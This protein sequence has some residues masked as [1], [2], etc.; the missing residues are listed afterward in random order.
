[1][2]QILVPYDFSSYSENALDFAYHFALHTSGRIKLLHVVEHNVQLSTRSQ[3]LMGL[4]QQFRKELVKNVTQHFET[5]KVSEKYKGVD[6]DFEVKVGIPLHSIMETIT[7]DKADLIIMGTKGASGIEEFLIGSNAEKVVRLAKCPVITIPL[8]AIF[9]SISDIAF[10]INFED[11]QAYIFDELK[12]IQAQF[13]SKIHLIWINT[14]GIVE[15]EAVIA[16]RL[17]NAASENNLENFEVH[18]LSAATPEKGILK[19]ARDNNNIDMIAMATH[20][21]RGLTHL[22]L[23]SIAENVVNHTHVPVWTTN[24]KT[25][26]GK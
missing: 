21:F 3:A 26:K 23:G 19:F 24:L 9:K 11:E 15:T 16:E 10:A 12:K 17:K 2:K 18:S 22:F 5:L 25:F 6:I 4:E 20:G 7:N 14:L 8:N 1:M 13:Q